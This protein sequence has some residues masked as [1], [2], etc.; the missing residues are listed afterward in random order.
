MQTRQ[1]P[2]ARNELAERT[3]PFYN[4][5]GVKSWLGI[6]DAELSRRISE[7]E[8]LV[9][10]TADGVSLIPAWQFNDD[11]TV[12]PDF[13]AVLKTLNAG[14]SEL[15][16]T[17][18]WTVA[19]WLSTKLA[20]LADTNTEDGKKEKSESVPLYQHLKNGNFTEEIKE[21]AEN[22]ARRWAAP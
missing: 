21:L 20:G 16:D 10:V 4:L 22:D 12:N 13:L 15:G 14:S 19:L 18:G 8:I 1:D 7:D 6:D 17:T 3:G 5:E 11:G 2:T 9:T